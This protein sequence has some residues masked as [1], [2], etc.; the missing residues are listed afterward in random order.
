MVISKKDSERLAVLEVRVSEHD[1]D[2]IHVFKHLEEMAKGLSNIY[3]TLN[4]ILFVL[5]GTALTL[6]VQEYG[7]HDAVLKLID[8]LM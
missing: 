7:I 2:F 8:A 1:K 5:V 6:I 3:T 4:R